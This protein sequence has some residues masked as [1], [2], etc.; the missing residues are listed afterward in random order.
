M[1]RFPYRG[2]THLFLLREGEILLSRRFNTGFMD[3]YYSVPAGHID[4]GETA[5]ECIVRESR[6]EIGIEVRST[7]LEMVHVMHRYSD[8]EIIYIDFF[9]TTREHAGEIRNCEP[10]KCD[11]LSWHPLDALPANTIPY[12]RRA[13]EAM[14]RKELYSEFGW[15][16]R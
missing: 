7:D 5:R 12:I 6:E 16:K 14:Q 4:G 2:A 11:E 13:I 8:E 1:S 3:G 15:E 10:E 9:V